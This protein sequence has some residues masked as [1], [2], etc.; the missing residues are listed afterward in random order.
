MKTSEIIIKEKQAQSE[1]AEILEYTLT[2]MRADNKQLAE[3]CMT[4]EN[5]GYFKGRADAYSVVISLLK[6]YKFE[7]DKE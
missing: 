1:M 6:H 4:P 5:R 7:G 2:H 3:M